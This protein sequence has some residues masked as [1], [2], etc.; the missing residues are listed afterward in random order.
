MMLAIK[1]KAGELLRSEMLHST[2]KL[3]GALAEFDFDARYRAEGRRAVEM[4]QARRRRIFAVR[5][6]NRQIS[7]LV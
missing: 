6:Q 7:C 1:L 3:L 2:L 5:L 4:T